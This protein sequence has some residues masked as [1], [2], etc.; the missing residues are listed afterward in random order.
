MLDSRHHQ[1]K[2]GEDYV[3]ALA[4]AAGM[5]VLE[6][7]PDVDGVDLTLRLPGLVDGVYSPFADVQ[8]KTT[9]KPRARGGEWHFDG[10]TEVQF[11]KLAGADYSAPRFLFLICVPATADQYASVNPDGLLLRRLGYFTSLEHESRIERPST[12]RRRPIRV[13]IG[14]VLTVQSL[15]SLV[16]P[17]ARTELG[18]AG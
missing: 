15:R 8:V 13:P 18:Q 2:F 9:S 17:G 16:M 14:N 12:T 4:S 5:L 10:L 1:G 7:K 6:H 3:R 11:N